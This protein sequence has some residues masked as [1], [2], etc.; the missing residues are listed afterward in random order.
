MPA[1]DQ[2]LRTLATVTEGIDD[3]R[4]QVVGVDVETADDETCGTVRLEGTVFED[5]VPDGVRV[6]ACDC[7]VS[8]SGALQFELTVVSDETGVLETDSADASPDASEQDVDAETSEPRSGPDETGGES[9]AETSAGNGNA[10]AP[11]QADG[12]AP[13][14][15][16]D[17][18]AVDD[19]SD[20][21]D[22][23][24]PPYR[25]PDRLKAVY[26]EERTFQEMTDALGVDVTPQTVR[27]YMIDHD[28][29][30]PQPQPAIGP[31]DA[32]RLDTNPSSGDDTED[33]PDV[34]GT[35]VDDAS[36]EAP[37]A[38]ESESDGLPAEESE[39]DES[40][41][42]SDPTDASDSVPEPA[43]D[44][45]IP[46][47]TVCDVDGAEAHTLGELVDA[48]VGAR[49][50][51]EVQSTLGVD[52]E[53]TRAL[54]EACD[55]MDLV[56]GRIDRGEGPDEPTVVD[57]VA[58]AISDPSDDPVDGFGD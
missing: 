54:L 52:A 53:T 32:D 42:E 41:A 24:V 28:V 6:T 31:E 56:A 25:D 8:D 11:E 16:E 27:R 45:E 51:Y 22:D 39:P 14:M 15:D 38:D 18:E 34:D 10:G 55:L 37:G 4:Y 23:S 47:E 17:G 29:H 57:R 1:I 44:E 49:T 20:P 36:P 35:D 12:A 5:G 40:R 58:G 13:A 21:T 30:E 48:A 3:D 33:E 46:L 9:V 43:V 2:G 26:D 19:E 50:M 7:S